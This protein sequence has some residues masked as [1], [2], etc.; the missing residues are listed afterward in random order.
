MGKN[1]PII[2][3]E[4][5]S[6][7][8]G[9]KRALDNISITINMGEHTAIVGPNG[10]GKSTV[11]KVISRDLYPLFNSGLKARVLDKE[12]WNVFELRELL[13]IVSDDLQEDCHRGLC[14]KE[15]ILSGFFSSI[16][17]FYNHLVTKAMQKKAADMIDFLE[18]AHLAEKPM[19][20]MSSGEARRVLIARALVHDPKAL[21][22]D[23]P[24]NNLDL[25]ASRHFREI[26]R[27]IANSGKTIIL[28]THHLHDI[29][30]EINRLIFLKNGKVFKDGKKEVLLSS[31]NLS[32]LFGVS[33]KVNFEN[34]FY[35]AW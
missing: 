7:M 28:V 22:L 9:G 24:S 18:I 15:I 23:E 10:S 21:I 3:L 14:A 4:N 1:R 29:I 5:L 8:L 26:I 25:H 33:V 11:I 30:P 2:E 13:G 6:V 19:T 31:S 16:G 20:E 34:G 35:N 32:E 12:N 27:K 17:L